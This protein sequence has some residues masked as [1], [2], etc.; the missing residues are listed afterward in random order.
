MQRLTL[1]T[2]PDAAVVQNTA[3][4]R[5]SPSERVALASAMSE[6]ARTISLAGFRARRPELG[7]RDLIL[8]LVRLIYGL[9]LRERPASQ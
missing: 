4:S 7:D 3:W 1:D 2:S 8:E 9:D 6:D 5:M